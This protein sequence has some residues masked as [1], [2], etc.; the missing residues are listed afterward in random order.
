MTEF[1]AVRDRHLLLRIEQ[2]LAHMAA[3]KERLA[4]AQARAQTLEAVGER[5]AALEETQSRV[6]LHLTSLQ[7]MLL[8]AAGRSL[9]CVSAPV[10][11]ARG[12]PRRRS[13]GARPG[14]GG[15][16]PEWQPWRGGV[17]C[18]DAACAEQRRPND[19]CDVVAARP[20]SEGPMEDERGLRRR[21]LDKR[22]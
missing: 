1:C 19:E 16:R 4:P 17:V 18:F 21:V 12:A 8:P 9:S 11:S 3:R 6:L 7:E 15:A 10:D 5:V 20:C 14:A 2:L 13:P 22:E